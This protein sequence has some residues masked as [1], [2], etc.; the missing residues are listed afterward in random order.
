MLPHHACKPPKA[1]TK[2]CSRCRDLTKAGTGSCIIQPPGA[3]ENSLDI[4]AQ[5]AAPLLLLPLP[6]Q[7]KRKSTEQIYDRR[8]V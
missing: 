7:G 3:K 5:A 2:A 4:E 6:Q 1:N 8:A